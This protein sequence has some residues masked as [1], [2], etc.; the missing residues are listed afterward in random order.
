MRLVRSALL[1]A[2]LPALAL[3][4]GCSG[5]ASPGAV[6][7]AAAPTRGHELHLTVP[8][9]TF[10]V[11][12]GAPVTHLT[13]DDTRD[14][15]ARDAP[16][17]Q[18][19]VPLTWSFNPSAV[20]VVDTRGHQAELA[21]AAGEATYAVGSVDRTSTPPRSVYL[22]VADPSDVAV[23][24]TFDG[25]TA[26]ATDADV[27]LG[28]A[29]RQQ[30]VACRGWTGGRDVGCT[31]SAYDTEWA[32]RWAPS[33]RH[34]VVVDADV[35]LAKQTVR[36]GGATTYYEPVDGTLRVRLQGTPGAVPVQQ[37][38][39][40]QCGFRGRTTL[41]TSLDHPRLGLALTC[42]LDRS[43][44]DGSSRGPASLRVRTR[45]DVRLP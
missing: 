29:G 18:R 37:D 2:A 19:Y 39:L 21:L 25:R 36:S 34:Y 24:A 17:G 44:S 26:T 27:E 5:D 20:S 41:A 45:I 13:A 38:P 12:L 10:T 40:E 14:R 42:S 32:G 31:L 9:G 16:D 43:G 22:A 28:A 1:V 7:N 35:S 33:G 8:S 4:A 3:V 11:T 15:S 30:D 6:V 23:A